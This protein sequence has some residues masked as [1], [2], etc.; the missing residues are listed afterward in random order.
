MNVYSSFMQNCQNLK[1]TKMSFSRQ[2]D[3]ANLVYPDN[4]ILFRAKNKMRC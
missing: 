1:A 2:M 3:K 4:R